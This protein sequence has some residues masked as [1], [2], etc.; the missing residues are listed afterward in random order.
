MFD[1]ALKR[2]TRMSVK[3]EKSPQYSDKRRR[4]VIGIKG[5]IAHLLVPPSSKPSVV[6]IKILS[7]AAHAEAGELD[8]PGLSTLNSSGKETHTIPFNSPQ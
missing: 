7:R 1:V 3:R 8:Q 5:G 6:E 2:C 4:C